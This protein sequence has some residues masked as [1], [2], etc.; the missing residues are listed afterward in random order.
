MNTITIDLDQLSVTDNLSN[1]I[2]DSSVWLV[3]TD[4]YESELSEIHQAMLDTNYLEV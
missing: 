4:R 1:L 2:N 3:D